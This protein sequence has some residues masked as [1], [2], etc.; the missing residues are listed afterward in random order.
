MA[1]PKHY[2]SSRHT[3]KAMMFTLRPRWNFVVLAIISGVVGY[4][5]YSSLLTSASFGD[6]QAEQYA[7]LILTVTI[8][9]VC[10]FMIIATA[11]M[12]HTHL[13]KRRMPKHGG[14]HRRRRG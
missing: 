14:K 1:G 5:F 12:W 2:L 13:W 10:F 4:G 9:L 7:M 6:V 11:R 8:L 3:G